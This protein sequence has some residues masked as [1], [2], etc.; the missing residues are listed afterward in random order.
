MSNQYIIQPATLHD[1][2]AILKIVNSAY[3]GQEGSKSWTSEG[4][5]VTGARITEDNLRN[6]LQQPGVTILR[7]ANEQ[8]FI[9]GCVLLEKKPDTLY[10]GMLSVDPQIQA[11][12]IGKTLLAQAETF[13]QQHQYKTI[14]I[15]VIDRRHEL[16]DWYKR[17]GYKLTGNII[18]FTNPSSTAI[19]E[20][21][22]VELQKD[23]M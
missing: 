11:S 5:L 3:H 13:A 8:G 17:K 12:G 9:V 1:V 4:H 18:P 2:P 22:F 7:C 6:Y 21:S 14:T 23:L 15:T 19:G 16:I 10:L 20:F